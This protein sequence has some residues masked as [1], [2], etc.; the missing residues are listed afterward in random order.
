MLSEN[1]VG[2]AGKL[3]DVTNVTAFLIFL[4]ALICF[5]LLGSNSPLSG[6]TGMFC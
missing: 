3:A 6:L 1:H 4:I 2:S 5:V